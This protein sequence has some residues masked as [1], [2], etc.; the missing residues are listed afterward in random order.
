MAPRQ[1]L[2]DWDW[3]ATGIWTV[4]T[5][6]ELAAPVPP[7]LAIERGA[8]A[9]YDPHRAWRGK[10]S[11]DLID[12][13]QA[14]NDRGEEVQGVNAHEYTDEERIEFWARGRGL[15]ARVQ[16]QLGPEYEVV[17]RTPEAYLK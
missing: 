3:C 9:D 10:L 11:D 4:P 14:W 1:V 6:E 16:D 13:L 7:G 5:V 12:A 2:I 15:A 17:C 8:E